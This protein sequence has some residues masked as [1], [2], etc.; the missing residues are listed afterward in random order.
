MPFGAQPEG[1]ATRFRLWA[2]AAARV[3]LVVTAE[4]G[5]Q[6]APLAPRGDGWFETTLDV[7]AGTR[8]AYRIDGGLV[9]PDPASRS[10]PDDVHRPSRV[11][12]P[13]AYEWRDAAWRGRP[14]DEAVVYELHVGTFT[15]EGTFAGVARHLQHLRDLGVTTIEL[16]PLADFPGRRNWGYDGVLPFAPEASY[17]TPEDLKRL[18]DDAH[19]VGLMVLLDVV[20]NHFGP[21]GNYLHA[22]APQFFTSRHQTP[23]GAAINFDG[24]GSRTVRDFFIHNALYWLEEFHFDGLRLDA[25]HAII[26][27]SPQHLLDELTTAVRR[28]FGNERHVHLVLENDRNEA[29]WLVRTP[30]GAPRYATAQ[31]NDDF[32]HALHVL[33]TAERDGYYGDYADRP[34][35]RFARALAEGLVYQGEPSAFRDGASRGQ[36]SAGLPPVAFVTFAQNHDQ[37]GN[38]ALG[39]RLHRIANPRRLQT[40]LTCMLLA[41]AI[42]MLFMGDEFAASAP[43]LFFCDFEPELARA[44]TN[45]RREE[46]ARFE[47]FREPADRTL[48]PDPSAD[49]T[50]ARSRI[51]WTERESAAAS[52]W[53]E[54]HRRCLAIRRDRIVPLLGA[55]REG[56]SFEVVGEHVVHVRW[57]LADGRA[58]VLLASFAD[59]PVQVGDW[60][61]GERL[62]VSDPAVEASLATGAMPA[63]AVVLVLEAPR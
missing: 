48:I 36:P 53:L 37:I 55:I 18:V 22:Y 11:E 59:E 23:W 41:P 17:G 20:Y 2:P 25:L 63:D 44:V 26:D 61:R 60:S 54:F 32:H 28:H 8:Y 39:E 6:E 12:D 52:G 30:G 58:L 62:F 4:G 24:E 35:H 56:G 57:R 45:G 27:D 40:A 3:D 43:F 31:W 42:P 7:G 47:R 16:M 34:L 14:W 13:H 38:R 10:N 51:D 33:V 1:T 50:F 49:S 5:E 21:E 29:A 19:R 15:P 9:V 46:F